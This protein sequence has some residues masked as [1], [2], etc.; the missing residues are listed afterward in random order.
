MKKSLLLIISLFTVESISAGSYGDVYGA[1]PAANG[2]GN[3][4]NATSSGSAAVY[5]NV[6]GLGRLSAA[7]LAV[8]DYEIA[9]LEKQGNAKSKEDATKITPPKGNKTEKEKEMSDI[10]PTERQVIEEY[11][12]HPFYI[13]TPLRVYDAFTKDLLVNRNLKRPNKV[14]HE[15]S[16]QYNYAVPR[17]TTSAPNPDRLL[18]EKDHYVGIGLA[19]DFGS[20]FNMDRKIKFGLNVLAPASGNLLTVNDQNPTVHRALQY[21]VEN[22]RPT[23]MGG[24]GVEAWKDHLYLGI[25][26]TALASGQGSILMKNVNI[27]PDP[28]TP[29]QQAILEIKPIVNPTFGAQFHWGKFDL[30][31]SYRRETM[32]SIDPLAA[33]AQ[34]TLLAIQLDLDIALL[35]LFTP[36]VV[37]YG[38]A[39]HPTESWTLALDINRELWS[40][41]RISRTKRTYSEP[42]DLKD[43]TNYRFG[44]E[45][46]W[47]PDWKFR[48]G[49]AIRPSPIGELPGQTNWI[50]FNRTILTAGVGYVLFPDSFSFTDV[51][52][53]P[54]LIDLV[55]EY[56]KLEGRNIYKYNPTA[57]NPNYSF[58][59]NVWHAG[60][61]FS[62][63]F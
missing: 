3:A 61:S 62:I 34:T 52:K 29:D 56:Q 57:R 8:L 60:I 42:F 38:L 11:L 13:R 40:G 43:T 32:L 36:R 53:N 19:I 63:L 22:E 23:I 33:R 59:G 17:L 51:F 47:R 18:G 35:G 44:I 1:H 49:C 25:G 26:F 27:S 31:A 10:D 30:G 9:T 24:L 54:L 50:D 7:D 12:E 2:M 5:Y 4:V 15:L 46:K 16:I 20:I 14:S 39:F 6:A 48:T 21:G 41:F 28:V 58:G 37:S 45:Y 55:I